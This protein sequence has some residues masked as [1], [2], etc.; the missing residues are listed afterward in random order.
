MPDPR[1]EVLA[2]TRRARSRSPNAGVAASWS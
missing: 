2:P 1:T